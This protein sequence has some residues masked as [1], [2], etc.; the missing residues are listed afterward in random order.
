MKADPD[1]LA[2]FLK[3]APSTRWAVEFRVPRWL[4]DGVFAI[5]KE[6]GSAL[7]IHDMIDNHRR[8]ITAGWV[9]LC[10]HGDRYGGCYSHQYR[11]KLQR[12]CSA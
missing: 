7:C 5:L 3:A 12:I 9:Y 11:L 1:R 6:H 4:C 2:A 10:F 8:V